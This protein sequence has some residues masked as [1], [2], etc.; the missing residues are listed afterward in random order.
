MLQIVFDIDRVTS[1]KDQTAPY[2]LYNATRLFSIFR[3]FER[4]GAYSD[5]LDGIRAFCPEDFAEQC[6]SPR[7]VHFLLSRK[8]ILRNWVLRL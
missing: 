8:L 3:E 7:L 5:G 6:K 4:K 2:V 1:T